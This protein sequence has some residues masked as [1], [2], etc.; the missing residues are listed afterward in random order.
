MTRHAGPAL[1]DRETSCYQR[2]ARRRYETVRAHRRII[3]STD[4]GYHHPPKNG[5]GKHPC[6][7]HRRRSGQTY[8]R[9]RPPPLQSEVESGEGKKGKER[10]GVRRR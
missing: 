1:S 4:A 2:S 7:P 9:R 5:S 10:L 3:W 6:R 8:R